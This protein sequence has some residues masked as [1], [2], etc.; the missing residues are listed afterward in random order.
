MIKNKV[1]SLSPRP[2]IVVVM[3]HIDHGK[4]TLL[5]YIRKTNVAGREAGGI[6]QSIGAYE[7][8]HAGKKITFID[9]PGHEAFSKM[10]ARGAQ[11]ADLAILIVAADDGVKPQTLEVLEHIKSAKIPFIVA[12]NKIDKPE[13]DIVR[14]KNE[15]SQNG[16]YLE[17]M[18]GNIP[19]QEI[20]AK[21]G[22]GVNELLDL[23]LLAADLEDL[24]ADSNASCQGIIVE[25]KIDPRRGIT[26]ALIIKNGTLKFG[27]EIY[28]PSARGKV[29]IMEDF[30]GRPIKQATFSSPILVVGFEDLPQVGEE[31][32]VGK[33]NIAAQDKKII[34]NPIKT[35]AISELTDAPQKTALKLFLKADVSGSLEAL[36]GVIKSL[37][38]D[39]IRIEIISAEVGEILESDV[40]SAFPA[41]A[42]I[43][44]FK[45]KIRRV[46][47]S[48]ARSLGVEVITSDVIYELLQNLGKA[49][50]EIELSKK[51]REKGILEV[52]AIFNNRN[53]SEQIVGG[54]M[55]EGQFKKGSK[56]EIWRQAKKIGAAKI[57]NLQVGKI[58]SEETKAGQECG[59]LLNADI[60]I[61]TGD[62]LKAL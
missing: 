41:G 50:K 17:G 22:Q 9:T 30:L 39:N 48:L 42:K 26:A 61:K 33:E 52:L 53:I 35:E 29:K 58:D 34:L 43:V 54:K 13:A 15:L 7:I 62:Q 24:K 4:T 28:T 45:V 25:S 55:M 38:N 32:S 47:E 3:G 37:E 51:E 11:V 36:V 27:D 8:E 49:I 6:T 20:S 31:L 19:Y 16:I 46:A 60:T 21:T 57:N 56:L 40:K 14:V 10:R 23:I 2:P 44:G 5:D 1:E 18:G 59:I 12:I